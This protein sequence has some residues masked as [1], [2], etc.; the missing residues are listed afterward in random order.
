M[1]LIAEKNLKLNNQPNSIFFKL[2][3]K[4]KCFKNWNGTFTSMEGFK[5]SVEM[6]HLRYGKIIVD[7][8]SNVYK[9]NKRR[10]CI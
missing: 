1:F 10:Q 3:R 6:C 7:G 8:D 5:K 2:K 4:H 9:K